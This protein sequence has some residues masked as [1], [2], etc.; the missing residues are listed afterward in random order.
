MYDKPT[1]SYLFRALVE[2]ARRKHR[3]MTWTEARLMFKGATCAAIYRAQQSTT[4]RSY[5]R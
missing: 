4:A 1:R 3:D 5:G 2:D